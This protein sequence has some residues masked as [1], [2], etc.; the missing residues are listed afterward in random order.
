MANGKGIGLVNVFVEE[1]TVEH[2]ILGC[3]SFKDLWHEPTIKPLGFTL[4]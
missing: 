4:K 3:A 2:I 1:E